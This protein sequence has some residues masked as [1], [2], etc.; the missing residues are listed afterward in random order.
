MSSARLPE[1]GGLPLLA[2]APGPAPALD[3]TPAGLFRSSHTAHLVPCSGCGALNGRSALACWSCEADLLALAPFALAG[4]AAAAAEAPIVERVVE[5]APAAGTEVSSDGRHGLHLVARGSG[6]AAVHA[7][8]AVAAPGHT[9]D[10]PVLTALVEDTPRV[11]REHKAR[12]HQRPMIGLALAAFALLAAAAG[13]RWLWSPPA[14]IAGLPST[15]APRAEAA[16][17]RPF[18]LPAQGGEPELARLSFPPVEVAPE[19]SAADPPARKA[20]RSQPAA[21]VRTPSAAPRPVPKPREIRE[22]VSP[23]PAACTSNMAALGFCTLP[24]APAK[25]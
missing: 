4:P 16:L 17:E 7:A 8:T 18:S 9:L 24:P 21:P 6:P 12:Y 5:P 11:A 19:A 2:A 14:P 23:P 13:M 25:E 20:A 15:A 10:L 1:H 3:S 22:T